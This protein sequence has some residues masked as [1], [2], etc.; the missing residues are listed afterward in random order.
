[1]AASLRVASIFRSLVTST[2]YKVPMKPLTRRS[3]LKAK[4]YGKTNWRELVIDD[5]NTRTF[6][7]SA[8]PGSKERERVGGLLQPR[9]R[10]GGLSE[11]TRSVSLGHR[12]LETERIWLP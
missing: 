3:D 8:A 5:G 4:H 10:H 9:R 12:P 6:V 7:I 2:P 11:V 1:M